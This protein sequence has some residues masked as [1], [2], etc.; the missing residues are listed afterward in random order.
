MTFLDQINNKIEENK[1]EMLS[2]L[3]KL[4]SI[5][6][7]ATDELGVKPFGEGVQKAYKEM[8]DMATA[9]GFEVFNADNYG[10]HI[11][12]PGKGDGVV[13]IVGHLDVV[14]EGD[15]WEFEPYGGEI[16]D[17]FVRGRGTVDDKGPVIASYYAM[18][19][20]K[21]CGY[22]P[23]KTIRLILGLDEETDWKGMDYYLSRV[24]TLPDCGFTPDGDF[25]VIH[26][27]MGILVFD[28][29]KKLPPS[30]GKG[31]ELSS[32]RGGT[33]ANS[34]PDYARA[35]VMDPSGSGY[36]FIKEMVANA[37]KNKD[38]QINCKGIGKSFEISV[39]GVS[40]HG[41]HPERG[42]NAISILMDFLGG[43][44][45]I[46]DGVTDFIHFYNECIGYDLKG[47]N[48]G[49]FMTDEISGDLV[50][51]AGMVEVDKNTAKL[52]VNIRYPVT[53]EGEDVYERLLPVMT[54]YDM[55][56][57]KGKHKWP[58]HIN[59]DSRLVTSLMDIY[60]THTG[61]Q[62][63]EPLVIGGGTYARAMDNIVAFGARFPG[64]KELG[65][66]KNEQIAVD[67]MMKLTRIY[68][69][70]AYEL[71]RDENK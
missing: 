30:A 49:C 70:A 35:V 60:R 50:F 34:V 62:D 64:Q 65:H 20:L 11:D 4:I 42:V 61:D 22:E 68:A 41:A 27:E 9:D 71:S 16:A 17:G 48:I 6:S 38:W 21:D 24:E 33:A 36:A 47:E 23:D 40:A 12:F 13:G 39:T 29:V 67:D 55:G 8:L 15:N 58:L 43:L 26:A 31:L 32:I 10:G 45:F 1:T 46:N 54:Q 57:I 14:P 53:C 59:K 7:V 2:S 63:S 37:R 18:K 66:Q 3:S 69:D 52:T 44:D 25:P 19:A 56:I 51:N 28:I 5:R